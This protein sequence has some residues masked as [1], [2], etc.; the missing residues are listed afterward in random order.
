MT[1][2]NPLDHPICFSYPLRLTA[3]AEVAHV[4]FAMTIVDLLRPRTIL[5]LGTRDGVL[6]CAFCQAVRELKLEARCYGI[7]K[8]RLGNGDDAK[9]E[10]MFA[11]WKKAHDDLYAGFSRLL[12]SP[13]T[14][15]TD[16][17]DQGSVDLLHLNGNLSYES[18]RA[19]FAAWL[20]KLSSKSVVLLSETNLHQGMPGM[21]KLWAE[22][23]RDYPHFE[24]GHGGG[25]GVLATGTNIAEEIRPLLT[26]REPEL[27]V[28]REFFRQQGQRLKA[29]SNGTAAL[30]GVKDDELTTA[31][32]RIELL[33]A[34]LEVKA[35]EVE[36]R[37]KAFDVAVAELQEIQP[38]LEA[39]EEELALTFRELAQRSADFV[40]ASTQLQAIVA[41][42]AW[43]WVSRY[44]HIKNWIMGSLR[45]PRRQRAR[46]SPPPGS[47][48]RVGI[49]TKIPDP[50]IVGKGSALYVSGFCYHFEQKIKNLELLVDG[51]AQPV[52]AFNMPRHNEPDDQ[53][54]DP[55][56][57]SYRSGF[58]AILTFPE[59]AQ[60]SQVPL[61]LQATLGKGMMCRE[62]LVTLKLNPGTASRQR[63]SLR[64]H[65]SL[66]KP[67]VAIC[68]TTSNPPLD[69][70]T[71][72]I[73]SI[74][75]QSHSNWVCIIS[76]DGSRPEI[77]E[78]IQAITSQDKRFHVFPGSARLGFYNNF[79]RSISLAPDEAEYIALSD[80]DDYWHAD[81]LE[82]L[83]SQFDEST[84]L[85]YSDMNIVDEKGTRIANT[86]WTTRPNNFTNFASLLMANTITGAA[87]LFHRKLLPY[88]LP[89]PEK[90]GSPYHDHWI[91]CAAMA[92]GKVKYVD[93]ATYDYVQ[94]SANALG[95]Y[96]PAGRS[97]RQRVRGTM[98]AVMYLG[99]WL[100]VSLANWRL[101]YFYDLIREQ[102][103]CKVL[104]LRCGEQLTS[105]KKKSIFRITHVDESLTAFAW[106]A[107]RGLKDGGRRRE[108]LGAEQVFLLATVWKK[109]T[110]FK[111]W[112]GYGVPE[113][114]RY[115]S[116]VPPL[117][118]LAPAP[119]QPVIDAPPPL[120]QTFS[121]VQFTQQK[122]APLKLRIS[123]AAPMRIN[124]LI[125][126]ID[127]KHFFGGYITK[128]N[129]ARRL[130]EAG[131]NVRLVIVDICD[132]LPSVWRR[133][134]QL[135]DGLDQLFDKVETVYAYDRNKLLTVSEDDVFMAT[136]WWT[137]HIAHQATK[138]LK[139]SKFIYLIQEYEPFTFPMGTFASLA[140][141]TYDFPHYAV[142][143]TELLRDYF[144][145]NRLGVFS[146][147]AGEGEQAST[148]FQNCITSVGRITREEIAGRVPKKLLFYAR[149]EAH[150]ARN[151]FE[152][153]SLALSEAIAAGYF[154]GEWE[155]YGIGTVG[156]LAKVE[157]SDGVHMTLYPR[158]T[159][160][161]YREVLR[162]HDL[163]LSL[164]Y[165]PHPSLVPIEMASAGML[166]V[167]NTYANK[168]AAKLTGISSNIFAAEPTIDGIV[169][170]LKLSAEGIE[171]YERRVRGSHVIW[172]TRWEESF[173]DAVIG[174]M[175]EFIA[176]CMEKTDKTT[177]GIIT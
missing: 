152:M 175:E 156:T 173:S 53:F 66:D 96:A 100:R 14:N 113:D 154:Q 104:E 18:A 144:R 105:D 132:Y 12:P 60:P 170:G 125:P 155:F 108:T 158:Q 15:G 73:E 116:T 45:R 81:K 10:E 161:K 90:V 160:E 30:G 24:F 63:L 75:N 110:D 124:L 177:L 38:V 3:T 67:L 19:E 159:Q 13:A 55:E 46:V 69:L 146:A 25:L 135:Y 141:Q 33:S 61:A 122:I 129:L 87:S 4:S 72:Q 11:D 52:K 130:A 71:R 134:L 1:K 145:Q 119:A 95:H 165:T 20:P 79:E 62:E 65:Q 97:L 21:I 168:T 176:A 172:A 31:E 102:L 114:T 6:Y 27:S 86:Y 131:F 153:A 84:T 89:F 47:G 169:A 44:G 147:S 149:P 94:H 78:E 35:R 88:I 77:L 142:F 64:E 43:R 138:T 143:S 56:G 118:D 99:N 126:N 106:M 162:E 127:L 109:F 83:L 117:A 57:N 76:D 123:I 163:G 85:V 112:L 34:G 103:M 74:R 5:E 120:L 133:Q 151:M 98:L 40:Q 107:T 166:V 16:L 68:M 17:F 128:L 51:Q 58:W 148:S 29:S 139:K 167:T 36:A 111:L 115:I 59:I 39:T 48:L 42:R 9:P 23:K 2:F 28:V 93:R 137:A 174:K 121:Q 91:G 41:S 82:T 80:Q 22:L 8:G 164:M 7:G 150:A 92:V 26:A 37:K 49:D 101:V 70:F 140:N 171:D 54:P 157:L 136:T 50:I 32:R